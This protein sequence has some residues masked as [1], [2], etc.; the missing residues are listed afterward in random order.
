M[1]RSWQDYYWPGE[2]VLR[3]KLN[4]HDSDALAHAEAR[5]AAMRA[6]EIRRG[7]ID[8]PRTFDADHLRAIHRALFSDV[9]DWAGEI[10]QVSMRKGGIDF[11]S[12]DRIGVYLSDMARV[13]AET[14]WTE[15]DRDNVAKSAAR[16]Y[17]L[18][19]A[20][21]PAREGNG[22]ALK[23]FVNHVVEDAGYR[24]DYAAIDKDVWDQRS[25]MSM[26]DRGGH[27]PYPDELAPVFAHII[28]DLPAPP[29]PVVDPSLEQAIA[30]ARAASIDHPTAAGYRGTAYQAPSP[31]S[32]SSRTPPSRYRG[33]DYGR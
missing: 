33:G 15:L 20:A 6:D 4:E 24:F 32:P 17:A 1:T 11:A 21:H 10:R 25:A 22:R 26:P 3:N 27:D 5:I 30:A 18:G 16:V 31:S 14:P 2:R 12:P 28:R 29:T 19:N 23:I 13:V 9:Y 7:L 8:I